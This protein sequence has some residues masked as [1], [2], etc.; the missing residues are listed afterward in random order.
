MKYINYCRSCKS[1]TNINQN[2]AI[3]SPFLAKRIF[4]LDIAVHR[5]MFNVKVYCVKNV[6]FWV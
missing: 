3:L 6:N 5:I 1:T 4:D 2:G